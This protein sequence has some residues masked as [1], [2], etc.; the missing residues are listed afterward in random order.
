MNNSHKFSNLLFFTYRHRLLTTTAKFGAQSVHETSCKVIDYRLKMITPQMPTHT[1]DFRKTHFPHPDLDKVHGQPTIDQI[2]KIYKQ[3][4]QNAASITTNLG[5]GQHGF[6]PLVITAQ[7]WNAIPNI[8]PFVRP[9]NPGSFIPPTGRVTNADVALAR[10]RWETRLQNYTN[11]QHLEATLKNQLINAFDY[12]ILAG[13]RN[14]TTNNIDHSIP[15]IIKYLFEEYGELSPEELQQK[16]DDVKNYVYDTTLP[17]SAVFNEIEHLQD[18]HDLTGSTLPEATMIRLGY[19]ILNK[20][21]LFR[22][23]LIAWNNK[24]NNQKTWLNFQTHFRK[25][26]RDLKQVRALNI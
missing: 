10:A 2:V 6:L 23:A 25:A 15:T 14:R 5:G 24:N 13:L 21:Q 26:Y 12:E 18:L 8:Q 1:P 17:V 9:T 4:Q 22:E 16:E 19:I 3:L 20:T 11:C 7:Q